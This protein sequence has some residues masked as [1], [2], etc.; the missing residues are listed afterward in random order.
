VVVSVSEAEVDVV[1]SKVVDLVNGGSL[2]EITSEAEVV[3]SGE[4]VEISSFVVD[5]ILVLVDGLG[6]TGGDDVS[7][8]KVV[9][10]VWV[11]LGVSRLD[12]VLDMATG[13]KVT[14]P[15][16]EGSKTNVAVIVRW[17]GCAAFGLPL[18]IAYAR[19]TTRS[20]FV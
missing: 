19:S 18:Q 8:T 4:L 10:N 16:P 13:G 1:V 14:T 20:G 9:G 5:R 6:I 12:V 15:L 11:V 17:V 7:I 2:I 3:S